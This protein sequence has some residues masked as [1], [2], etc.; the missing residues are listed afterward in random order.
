MNI[1][2]LAIRLYR[3][4]SLVRAGTRAAVAVHHKIRRPQTRPCPYAG[5]TGCSA[6]FALEARKHGLRALPAVL[7]AMAVCGP[8]T[9]SAEW[10]IGARVGGCF[11][12]GQSWC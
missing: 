12:D 11:N 6:H 4:S 2:L 7:A 8:G 10:C 3:A 9:D 1:L 5:G